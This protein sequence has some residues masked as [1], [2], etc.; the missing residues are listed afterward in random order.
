MTEPI[1]S[2]WH[3]TLA[4]RTRRK[5]TEYF[6]IQFL[7]YNTTKCTF[8]CQKRNF[9]IHWPSSFLR[10]TNISLISSAMSLNQTF[11]YSLW[12]LPCLYSVFSEIYV[13]LFYILTVLGIKKFRLKMFI[14]LDCPVAIIHWKNHPFHIMILCSYSTVVYVF[15]PLETAEQYI[16]DLPHLPHAL[17]KKI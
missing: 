2:L 14:N 16:G 3:S 11:C 5:H 13:V 12:I 8:R 6:K 17:K 1:L 7:A 9:L 15:F 4:R 10:S